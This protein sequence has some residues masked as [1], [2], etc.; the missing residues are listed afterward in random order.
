HRILGN[1][2]GG[3]VVQTTF[4]VAQNGTLTMAYLA[5][6]FDQMQ[7]IPA[8]GTLPAWPLAIAT[9]DPVSLAT[10]N[11]PGFYNQQVFTWIRGSKASIDNTSLWAI[12]GER[13]QITT[14]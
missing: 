7:P 9:V 13:A 10:T 8:E 2:L 5:Q 1:I 3:S 12:V 6:P 4:S 11:V 14:V